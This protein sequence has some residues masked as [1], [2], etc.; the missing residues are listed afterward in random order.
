MDGYTN[1]MKM[2][3]SVQQASGAKLVEGLTNKS[4]VHGGYAS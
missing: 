2:F 1:E 3:P 4:S